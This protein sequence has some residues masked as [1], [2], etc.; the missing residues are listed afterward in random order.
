M[1]SI[2]CR[3][4]ILLLPFFAL[5]FGPL[6]FPV[7]GGTG[8]TGLGMV[9]PGA[10]GIAIGQGA[11]L[12]LPSDLKQPDSGTVRIARF[13]LSLSY[14]QPGGPSG[15][16]AIT[17]MYEYSDYNWSKEDLF[18][19]TNRFS[20][21]AIGLRQLGD[22]DWS[23]FGF[24]Q[25]SWVAE[26]SGGSLSRGFSGNLAGGPAYAFNRDF[27]LSAGLLL[28]ALPERNVRVFPIAALNWRIHPQWILRTLNGAVLTFLPDP[29]G[30]WQFDFTAEYRTRGIRLKSQNLPDGRRTAPAVEERAFAT[31]LN[32]SWRFHEN[33]LLQA[34]ADFLLAREW[35]FRAD[36]SGYRKVEADHA[37]ACGV[38]LDYLF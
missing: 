13:P 17:G 18:D 36:K 34:H 35:N 15:F 4:L 38:R 1:S 27:S 3:A 25:T 21:S 37:F 31:G 16:L 26:T 30:D 14:R 29:E 9:S 33:F 22:S 2:L 6:I 28:S 8:G 20:L 10:P 11:A 19:A 24:G 7:R 12:A 32:A 5:G 23:L